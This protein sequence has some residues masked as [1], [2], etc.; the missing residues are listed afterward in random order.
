[1]HRLFVGRRH[2]SGQY[3]Q[4]DMDRISEGLRKYTN[5][6]INYRRENTRGVVGSHFLVH[7]LYNVNVSLNYDLPIYLNK[8]ESMS[9]DLAM[10]LKMT[11]AFYKGKVHDKNGFY[12]KFNVSGGLKEIFIANTDDFNVFDFEK[13]WKD[14]ES[15]RV[16]YHPMTD[17]S[18]TVPDGYQTF[19][20]EGNVVLSI[21]IPMLA[22]QYY[23]WRKERRLMDEAYEPRSIEQFIQEIP[24]PNMLK[25]Q[26]DIVIMNR[27]IH[28]YFG[29]P[30]RASYSKHPF[31]IPDYSN[32]LNQLQKQAITELLPRKLDFDDI[33]FKIP[34][35]FA[36]SYHEIIKIPEYTFT[37]TIAWAIT[38]S[39]LPLIAF[40]VKQNKDFE[41]ERNKYHLNRLKNYFRISHTERILQSALSRPEFEEADSII[42][43]GILPY[44]D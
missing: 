39:R 41:N 44:L 43:N 11:S 31:Q 12:S 24:I 36:S 23:L 4:P 1:M 20:Y 17:L 22:G 40:L 35:V 8:V 25:S 6:I 3:R 29:L 21:N 34:L 26:T 33:L 32:R 9:Y 2:D 28:L 7:L 14:Y 10:A 18:L 27:F 19:G 13:N 5:R 16:M 37:R 42:K 30:I 38:L 15:I